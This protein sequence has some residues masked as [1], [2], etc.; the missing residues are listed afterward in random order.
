MDRQE[1]K[2]AY[3]ATDVG[4]GGILIESFMPGHHYGCS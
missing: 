3:P 2:A 4:L 1:L